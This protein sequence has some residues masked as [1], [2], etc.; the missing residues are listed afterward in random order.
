M[1]EHTV[2]YRH[3]RWS[4]FLCILFAYILMERSLLNQPLYL[5]LGGCCAISVKYE[6]SAF[7]HS[8]QGIKSISRLRL[9]DARIA[10]L[11]ERKHVGLGNVFGNKFLLSPPGV[12]QL[13]DS[14][15]RVS[16]FAY[17]TPLMFTLQPTHVS[18]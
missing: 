11:R 15:P 14:T 2:E 3:K 7:Q 4:E 1:Y 9:A 18:P 6:L 13:D 17:Q 10:G 8:L 16:L 12:V 5:W